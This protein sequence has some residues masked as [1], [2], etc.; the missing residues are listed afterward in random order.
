M[1]NVHISTI[2][3]HIQLEFV[4][5]DLKW[6]VTLLGIAYLDKHWKEKPYDSKVFRNLLTV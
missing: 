6:E 5:V 1:I 4:G 3:R 2:D